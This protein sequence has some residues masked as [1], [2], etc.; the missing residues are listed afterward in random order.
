[1]LWATEP[2]WHAHHAHTPSS[3]SITVHLLDILPQLPPDVITNDKPGIIVITIVLVFFNLVVWLLWLPLLPRQLN[4]PDDDLE[5]SPKSIFAD[6]SKSFFQPCTYF[7]R[8]LP[9]CQAGELKQ[10]L[11]ELKGPGI[12]VGFGM[13]FFWQI[14]K[15]WATQPI[16]GN[17]PEQ[18]PSFFLVML[19]N[20][21]RVTLPV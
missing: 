7:S 9:S 4:D 14:I 8:R 5:R 11:N 20:D 12:L 18:P 10:C 3:S 1:M 2:L 15:E 6:R 13:D 19:V 21:R 17:C 16:L